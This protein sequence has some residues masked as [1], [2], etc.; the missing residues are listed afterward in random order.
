METKCTLSV[1]FSFKNEE[2]VIPELLNRIRSVLNKECPNSYELIFVNDCSTDNSEQMLIEESKKHNDIKIITTAR[3][4]GVS[5]CVLLGM[6]YSSGEAVVYMDTDLQDPPEVIPELLRKWR[7]GNDVVHTV[8]LS[9]AGESEVKLFITHIGYKLIRWASSIDLMINAGDFKLLSRRAVNEVIKLKEKKPYMRGLVTWVGFKQDKIDYHREARG[10]GESKFAVFS[11]SVI[12][13]FLD[14]ALISFS[15][16][17]LKLFMI[18]GS[19]VSFLSF[20]YLPYVA[21]K[22]LLGYSIPENYLFIAVFFFLL[23]FIILGIGVLGLYISSIFFETKNRPNYII[24][25]TF[26]FEPNQNQDSSTKVIPTENTK[27]NISLNSFKHNEDIDNN[28]LVVEPK[29]MSAENYITGTAIL[30]VYNN[31]FGLIQV[32]R[33]VFN[34]NFYEIPRGF[35]EQNESLAVSASRELNEETGIKFD[36]EKL[37]DLG[38]IAPETGIIRGKV[39]LFAAEIE[40]E[41]SN[42]KVNDIGHIDFKF[43]SSYEMNKMI[44]NNSIQDI[45]TIIAFYKYQSYLAES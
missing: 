12:N 2:D 44:E 43:Y 9:R 31:T 34:E 30:P 23:G 25:H 37:I 13:N 45:Y 39:Q 24:D 33:F 11:T 6:E 4:A 17:P 35:I 7:E 29:V 10:G 36:S 16:L 38:V 1:I 20:L 14:S 3:N 42:F 18:F 5:P 40:S 8:R 32:K 27:F 15:D 41:A 21:L 19:F 22:R 26:G 28:F